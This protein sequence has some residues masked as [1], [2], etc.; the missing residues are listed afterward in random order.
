MTTRA[1]PRPDAVV[2]DGESSSSSLDVRPAT[3][4]PGDD[5]ESSDDDT[6]PNFYKLSKRMVERKRAQLKQLTGAPAAT[7]AGNHKSTARTDKMSYVAF[8]PAFVVARLARLDAAAPG[9]QA[10]VPAAVLEVRMAGLAALTTRLHRE[11]TGPRE[12]CCKLDE[13]LN[14]LTQVADTSG[15]DA[16]VI[17]GACST[18]ACL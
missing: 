16:F 7:R 17:T 5:G 15:G 14:T 9:L 18:S 6:A 4:L 2:G 8:M 11:F 1:A 12:L 3:Y 13:L 10:C